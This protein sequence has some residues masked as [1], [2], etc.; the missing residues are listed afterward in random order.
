MPISTCRS[1][2]SNLKKINWYAVF[3]PYMINN[4]YENSNYSFN[5][6]I[7]VSQYHQYYICKSYQLQNLNL[8]TSRL[9]VR[10]CQK[11]A[12]LL[13]FYKLVIEL[14]QVDMGIYHFKMHFKLVSYQ[15]SYCYLGSES[16]TNMIKLYFE[17]FIANY[18]KPFNKKR[19]CC[20]NRYWLGSSS[21]FLPGSL[22]LKEFVTFPQWEFGRQLT[23]INLGVWRKSENLFLKKTSSKA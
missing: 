15:M 18:F 19:P 23:S 20:Y 9:M 7:I 1:S 4:L 5:I 8:C 13:F 16:K 17:F 14:L 21:C 3:W 10:Y 12:F 22:L 6:M 2:I 11:T